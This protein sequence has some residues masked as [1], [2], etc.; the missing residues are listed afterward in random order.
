VLIFTR[1]RSQHFRADLGCSGADAAPTVSTL[2]IP[3]V[4]FLTEQVDHPCRPVLEV[5]Q[6]A[7]FPSS[8]R[9]RLRHYG[10]HRAACH[11]RHQAWRRQGQES[12]Q[13]LPARPPAP[14][15]RAGADPVAE[16]LTAAALPPV[17]HEQVQRIAGPASSH[18]GKRSKL[19]G[20]FIQDWLS[21]CNRSLLGVE[22][23]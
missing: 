14:L 3:R 6:P 13:Q 7:L 9:T 19:F 18:H 20:E 8:V 16:L 2:P 21:S 11:R 5:Y 12:G 10:A 17:G 23:Q 4:D 1:G 15:A 22:D